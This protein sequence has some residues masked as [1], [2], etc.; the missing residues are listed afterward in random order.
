MR[1]RYSR[2]IRRYRGKIAKGIQNQVT[3]QPTRRRVIT[4][5]DE[6]PIRDQYRD[7]E[8]LLTTVYRGPEGQDVVQYGGE[9][10]PEPSWWDRLT[11]AGVA[12]KPED[13]SYWDVVVDSWN[14]PITQFVGKM[15]LGQMVS[16]VKKE[17][18]SDKPSGQMKKDIAYLNQ[19]AQDV[20]DSVKNYY[21][22]S[23]AKQFIDN[24]DWALREKWEQFKGRKANPRFPTQQ[25]VDVPD[26]TFDWSAVSNVDMKKFP[27]YM[28]FDKS[29]FDYGFDD[30]ENPFA[31]EDYDPEETF[32]R[33][34]DYMRDSLHRPFRDFEMVQATNEDWDPSEEEVDWK[35][36]KR[37][38]SAE[39]L[40]RLY[41]LE[42]M[43]TPLDFPYSNAPRIAW[44]MEDHSATGRDR[45]EDYLGVTLPRREGKVL[46]RSSKT[47]WSPKKFSP[48]KSSVRQQPKTSWRKTST[49]RSPIRT[50]SR[51]VEPISRQSKFL[52]RV[53]EE[54]HGTNPLFAQR[55]ANQIEEH[56]KKTYGI[57]KTYY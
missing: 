23:G 42:D 52:D 3:N 48:V 1:K 26:D 31:D 54:I 43:N 15:L 6:R 10:K 22:D 24:T 30:E 34:P 14:H 36:P 40:A 35:P 37:D 45:V 5:E 19:K 56:K 28:K 27:G 8:G 44:Q 25:Q 12:W 2:P 18:K 55:M 16:D 47:K 11:T 50:R 21:R 33:D 49:R 7:A 13:Q 46:P 20:Q 51:A 38:K 29:N 32:G 17:L 39:Q 4:D 53:N 57:R 41:S 9:K